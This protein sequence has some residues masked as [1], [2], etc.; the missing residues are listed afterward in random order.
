MTFRIEDIK[1][2]QSNLQI[3][4]TAKTTHN[5]PPPQTPA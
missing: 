3:V 1:F 4:M 2:S 5:Y